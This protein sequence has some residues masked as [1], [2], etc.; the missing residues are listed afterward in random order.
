MLAFEAA[1]GYGFT[2][3]LA[4]FAFTMTTFAKTSLFPALVAGLLRIISL[5]KPGMATI[6]IVCSS[7]LTLR[8]P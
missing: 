4:G 5:T 6:P 8:M 7:P 1:T 2:I 3:F